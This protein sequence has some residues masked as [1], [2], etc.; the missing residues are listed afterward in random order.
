MT[1]AWKTVGPLRLTESYRKYAYSQLRIYPS[2]YFIPRHFTGQ[3]YQ[4]SDPIYAD[5]LWGST[6]RGYDQIH[7]LDVDGAAAPMPEATAPVAA[8]PVPAPVAAPAA[9][10]APRHVQAGKA[11]R[12][13]F[14]PARADQ[15]RNRHGPVSRCCARSAG[16]ARAACRLRGLA[17]H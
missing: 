2:H 15:Q 8:A 9:T 1:L 10:A 5:Q 3:T 4:G 16:Q 17:D 14:R 11:P 7:Q 6:K 13:L 12:A